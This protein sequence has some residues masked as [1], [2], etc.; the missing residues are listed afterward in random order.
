[1][2]ESTLATLKESLSD[3]SSSQQ[4]TSIALDTIAVKLRLTHLDLIITIQSWKVLKKYY[5]KSK[6]FST[7]ALMSL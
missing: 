5:A 4:N 3:D 1:M 7:Q 6:T 2:E